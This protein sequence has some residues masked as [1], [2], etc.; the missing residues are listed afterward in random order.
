MAKR[1]R[2]STVSTDSWETDWFKCCLCQEDT[3]E[4][5]SASKEGFK[6]L[7]NNVPKFNELNSLPIPLDIRRLDEGGG[8]ERT[9]LDREA[10]YH[11]SCRLKFNNTKLKRATDKA[12]SK[13]KPKDDTCESPFTR[14]SSDVS[15]N[16]GIVKCFLCDEEAPLSSLREAMTMK[17]N[18]RLK[19]CAETLQDKKLL[20]KLSAGDVVAQEM[21]YH[22]ACLASLYNKAKACEKKNETKSSESET[23]TDVENIA[24]AE[25]V[26]YIFE[27]ARNGDEST[28][29]RLADLVHMFDK[30]LYQLNGESTSIHSTRLKNMLMTKIPDLQAYMKGRDVLLLFEKD[31]GPA[32]S[33]ACN[34][35]DTS[36]MAKTAEFVRAH[37]KEHKTKFKGP[38]TDEDIQNA[39]PRCLLELVRMIEHGPDIQSQLEND[40]SQSD[41]A[42]A[43][44]LMYNYHAKVPKKAEVQRH[45]VERET[46]ICIYIGLL[47]YAKT[48]KRQLIDSL[49][50]HGLC[51]SYH[52]VLE[53][54]TQ[55]GQAVVERFLSEGLVCPT[56]LRKGIFTT[57]A[58]DNIDHNPSST[59]AKSS[60]HGTGISIF[61]HPSEDNSGE[62]RETVIIGKKPS[63]KR[64]PTLPDKYSNVKPAFLKKKPSPP[65]TPGILM[66]IP[67]DDYLVESIKDEYEW[68]NAVHLTSDDLEHVSW[69]SFHSSRKRGPSVEVSLTSLLPL[70]QE[71]AHSV[72]MIKHAMDKVKEI[73]SFLNPGQ[74]PVI[75]ADQP[76]FVLAKQIQWEWPNLYGE[77]KFVV[78]FGGLHIEMA[79]FRIL[80][81][82][83]R[84]SGWTGALIEAEIAT[85]GTAESF[86][87]CFNVPRT[88]HA[89]QVTACALFELLMSAYEISNEGNLGNESV[90][91][92]DLMNW[93]KDKEN[94][95]PQFKFWSSVLN[96][97]L[98]VLSCIRSFRESDFELYKQ[99]LANLI[100]HF[101][102]LDR[103]NYA[104][105]LPI[106][107]RDMV[108]LHQTNPDIAR[109]FAKG[110]FTVRKTTKVFSNMAID[111][112]HEQNNALI[113]GDGGAIGL[114]EDPSALRRWMVSGP[115]I[116]RVI[117]EF[118]TVVNPH[119]SSEVSKHHE[120]T[121]PSQKVF[122]EEV[123]RFVKTV[124]D[125]GNP[126][127]EDSSDLYKLDTKD[128]VDSEIAAIETL[129]EIG[130]RQYNE[131][132][133]RITNEGTP[134]FY[135]AIKKN[136]LPLF[137]RKVK[138]KAGAVKGKLQ[139]L[140]NDCNL[141]SR[142][143]ISCQSRQCDMEEF[144]SHENQTT[145]PSLAQDGELYTGVKSQL[146][147]VLEEN[148]TT[149]ANDPD[150]DALVI[151][152]AA[153]VNSKPPRDSSTFD[154]YAHDTIL[155][156]IDSCLRKYLRVDIV[157]DVY[158]QD[159]L[160]AS[161]REKRGSGVR[162]KVVGTVKTP[163]AWNSFLRDNDNKTELF[164]FLAESIVTIETNRQVFVTLGET[165]LTNRN[166]DTSLL[167]PCNHEEADTRMF[168]HV[169]HAAVN[170][171]K[172]V[173]M[174]STDTDV[175]VLA[176]SVF[177]KLG[178]D[179]L[180][181]GFGRN[182]DFRWLPVHDIGDS[183]GIP[184]SA[185]PFFHAFTGC[186]TVSAF[187]GKGKK[188]A[189]QVWE[190][191]PDATEVFARLGMSP[192]SITE[193]DIEILEA[194]V[195]ILYDRATT[196]F[197]VNEARFELFARKQRAFD[198]IPPTRDALIQHIRR[199]VYQ[200]GYVWSQIVACSQTLPSPEHW[201][202][203][204][205]NDD[206]I[207]KPKW[208]LLPSV[209][210][211]CQELTKCGCK[212]TTCVGNCKCYRSGL[213][214]TGLCTCNCQI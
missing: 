202:W 141:F 207:W 177:P 99:S 122:L 173:S 81:D 124:N 132:L 19:Q 125:F 136:N 85:S 161:T 199:A 88:R 149:A 192:A 168:I 93:C 91:F 44:L 158:I 49:F 178:L 16:L 15:V 112:A 7:A 126:F 176:V 36:N 76:L 127:L 150:S 191:F 23:V 27:T 92:E 57:S 96:L 8:I 13:N 48:R 32:I 84:D 105:W 25:L 204:K 169:K 82:I 205:D 3:G 143:F 120:D 180:W 106:H 90:T 151:D 159:S 31:V 193:D 198:A 130:L 38:F 67:D 65:N 188:T 51:I 94:A 208:T 2:L 68:L 116:S 78:M 179:K 110:N 115:E 182:K 118:E 185:L 128:V 117:D 77:N 95:H 69:S 60:F 184:V 28:V 114:T 12:D 54:S 165:V 154:D 153:M 79:C 146:M 137:S 73:T 167:V 190:V 183:L 62:E 4:P 175:V 121:V 80:G 6:M 139:H 59:T 104:R 144:F 66:K 210:A 102:G 152:G 174:Y 196:T 52:R 206:T 181:I 11:T 156:Y 123:Q 148:I 162:R 10:K 211:S 87:A 197:A 147:D 203:M 97:E 56:V 129:R 17:I 43:Q 194:F 14:R 34:Y 113:K 145:P 26:N 9:M 138:P 172:E 213:P 155:P 135:D 47:I 22:P 58:V 72:A 108:S 98:L 131:F 100:P 55:F 209:A 29:F 64:I 37:M 109:E 195:C 20:A 212:K 133:E 186:D 111:Q 142:L 24:L 45:S 187:R 107:V 42:I 74:T 35:D 18:D 71:A 86:L 166:S 61:Q 5:L 33:L 41:M 119:K 101:F 140:K 46:P 1:I 89:H 160:K 63:S 103:V 83:L 70:F 201:G 53:I 200:G 163:K 157:F 164:K 214:C 75:T 39:V 40:V 21:K 30:R 134:D 189:W 171:C 170:G 50:Q